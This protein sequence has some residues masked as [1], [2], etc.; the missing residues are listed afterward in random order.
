MVKNNFEKA[1]FAG[2]CL[3]CTEAIFQRLKGAASV[4]SGYAGKGSQ[5][6]YEQVSSGT[7]DF[8]EA[9]Q[10]IFNPDEISYP[11]LLDVFWAT[12]DPTTLNR[13]GADAGAQYRSVIFYHNEGQRKEALKSMEKLD[14]SGK[15]EDNIITEILPL[16]NFYEAE[17]YHQDF[18][19]QNRSFPYCRVIID[20]KIKKLYKEF[21]DK[22]NGLD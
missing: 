22:V 1:T 17:K 14:N 8:A 13:Q 20:P 21:G 11:E 3:W 7:T 12:H 18:Y 9:I 4:V 10:I 19:N 16:A 2:G 6:T 5:P 15:Y